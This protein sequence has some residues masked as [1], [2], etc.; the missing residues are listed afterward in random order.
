M[1]PPGAVMSGFNVSSGVTPQ[2]EKSDISPESGVVHLAV[3]GGDRQLPG[4]FL[5]SGQ[6]LAVRL[7][8]EGAGQVVLV[9]L[10]IQHT[11]FKLL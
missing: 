1:L 10:H 3:D 11:R 9:Q 5:Q 2:E 7:G 4:A 6:G 8:D